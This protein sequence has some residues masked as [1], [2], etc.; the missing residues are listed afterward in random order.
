MNLDAVFRGYLFEHFIAEAILGT[1]EQKLL[2]A[3]RQPLVGPDTASRGI[4]FN[5]VK[6][7][8]PILLIDMQSHRSSKSL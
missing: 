6:E 1:L 3:C 4:L 7:A 5:R 8:A 2:E